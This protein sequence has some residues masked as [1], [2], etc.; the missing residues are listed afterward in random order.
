MIFLT[1]FMPL[2]SFYTPW[3]HQKTEGFWE[4]LGWKFWGF[5][6]CWGEGEGV[7][8]RKQWYEMG[9]VTRLWHIFLVEY[10][11][12]NLKIILTLS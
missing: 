9:Y 5:L 6:G 8:E 10:N 3:K 4:F 7:I 11:F 1:N 12:R 2:T